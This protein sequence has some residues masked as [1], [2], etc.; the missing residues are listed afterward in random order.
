MYVIIC[1]PEHDGG[2]SCV[3]QIAKAKE[4]AFAEV[5]AIRLREVLVECVQNTV[6]NIEKKLTRTK[7]ELEE[8]QEVRGVCSQTGESINGNMNEWVH[9]SK[10]T[11]GTH[12]IIRNRSMQNYS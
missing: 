8:D 10:R 5:R 6:D 3:A 2:F 12:M 9:Q 1:S 11:T 7:E 4:V